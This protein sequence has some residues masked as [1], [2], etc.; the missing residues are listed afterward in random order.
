MRTFLAK[1]TRRVRKLIGQ[2]RARHE[3]QALADSACEPTR[4]VGRA[5]LT[6]LAEPAPPAEL[7]RI[8]QLRGRLLAC[9]QPVEMPDFGA[10]SVHDRDAGA[11]RSSTIAALCR[12]ASK[13]SHAGR[14]LY[15]LILRFAPERAL[16][17]G[18]ALGISAAYEAT[19]LA[20]TGGRLV[21]LEGAPALAELARANLAELGLENVE[22][23]TGRFAETLAP[24]L[25]RLGALGYAFIDGHHDQQATI[26]YFTTIR[27]ALTT[28][29]VVVLDDIA[30][31]AGMTRAWR[32]VRSDPAVRVSVGLGTMGV[33]VVGDESIP[34]QRVDVWVL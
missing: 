31:S 26:D 2:T 20:T 22:V 15:E 24:T 34:R 5:V 9:E 1:A 25:D 3:L 17:L 16:E 14:L 11:Q 33:C 29:A 4:H 23:V 8:E 30:W 32:A 13:P 12:G 28:P 7:E 21:T 6:A 27:P 18:A 10:G 19:A